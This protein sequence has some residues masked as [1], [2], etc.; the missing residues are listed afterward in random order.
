MSSKTD[1]LKDELV[2][3]TN[4]G[5][6]AVAMFVEVVLQLKAAER[7]L[8]QLRNDIGFIDQ[9]A[10][11]SGKHPFTFLRSMLEEYDSSYPNICQNESLS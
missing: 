5:S 3:L 4:D 8:S 7:V 6:T 10:V 9:N 1:Q 2:A 11:D